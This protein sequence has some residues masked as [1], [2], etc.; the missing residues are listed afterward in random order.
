MRMKLLL[1]CVPAALAAVG[2]ALAAAPEATAGGGRARFDFVPGG[3]DVAITGHGRDAARYY[4]TYTLTNPMDEARTPRLYLEVKTDT[5]KTYGDFADAAVVKAAS[6]ATKAAGI[7]S[8]ADLRGGEIPAG[9]SATGVA[10]FG[11]IDPNA[12]DI[13]V[14]VYGLWDPI[15]RTRQGKVL[16]ETRVLVLKFERHGDEYDRPMDPI[17]LVGTTQEVE[18]EVVELYSTLAEKKK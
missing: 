12:D 5:N 14:R 13:T 17:N 16:K 15:I 7:K 8:T 9:G 10:N 3:M 4:L 1:W 18:G 6:K 11:N 2:A